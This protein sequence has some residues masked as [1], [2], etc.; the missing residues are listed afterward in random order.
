MP[1]FNP[2]YAD[3]NTLTLTTAHWYV[4]GRLWSLLSTVF[5]IL[6]HQGN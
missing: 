6:C 4:G 1:E 3:I 5:L 2:I